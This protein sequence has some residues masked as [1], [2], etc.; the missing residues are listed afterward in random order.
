MI[1]SWNKVIYIF[2]SNQL[3]IAK[4]KKPLWKWNILATTISSWAWTFRIKQFQ[5]MEIYQW[6][7]KFRWHGISIINLT[8]VLIQFIKNKI[9]KWNT[10]FMECRAYSIAHHV[11]ILLSFS[12]VSTNTDTLVFVFDI[13]PLCFIT[14][15]LG[16][17]ISLWPRK[18]CTNMH[19]RNQE[20]LEQLQE[21]RSCH[22]CQ[23]QTFL[24]SFLAIGRIF[25]VKI[26]LTLSYT[27]HYPCQEFKTF[28]YCHESVSGYRL[29]R[30]RFWPWKYSW[31][32][33]LVPQVCW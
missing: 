28:R 13:C 25:K 2:A 11:C 9:Y 29:H 15:F 18:R 23:Q 17:G 22:S 5:W 26:F 24:G 19:Q 7:Q 27:Y 20:N 14:V 3:E 21:Q 6:A 31:A 33:C 10:K 16:T 12:S 1:S 30:P 8:S 4:K 32:P